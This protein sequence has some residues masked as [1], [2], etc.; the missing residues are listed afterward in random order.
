MKLVACTVLFGWLLIIWPPLRQ[1]AVSIAV[2]QALEHLTLSTP[3]PE[4]FQSREAVRALNGEKKE[5][6]LQATFFD[7]ESGEWMQLHTETG[8]DRSL[9]AARRGAAKAYC[10]STIEQYS[11]RG[12]ELVEI[13]PKELIKDF[14]SFDFS[15]EMNVRFT[16]KGET[17]EL[18]YVKLRIFFSNLGFLVGVHSSNLERLNSL[19][20]FVKGVVPK[21]K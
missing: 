20:E 12:Y 18:R 10:N 19:D 9:N 8:F 2:E 4:R 16:F 15:K 7:Q 14:D 5:I 3:V 13:S 21:A 11:K 1:E 6:A 17:G